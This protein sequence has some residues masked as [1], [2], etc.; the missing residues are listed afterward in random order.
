MALVLWQP[1]ERES[2]T[3]LVDGWS[4]EIVTV[5]FTLKKPQHWNHAG[6]TGIALGKAVFRLGLVLVRE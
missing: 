2:D 4:G 1:A 3:Q 6:S 5:L